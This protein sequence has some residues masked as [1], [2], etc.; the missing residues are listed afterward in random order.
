MFRA[1]YSSVDRMAV[2]QALGECASQ[3]GDLDRKIIPAL[4]KALGDRESWGVREAAAKALG[5]SVEQWGGLAGEII[6][7]L[8]NALDDQRLAVSTAAGKALGKGAAQ[9]RELAKEIISELFKILRDEKLLKM[10]RDGA[11]PGILIEARHALKECMSQMEGWKSV[12]RDELYYDREAEGQASENTAEKVKL[13]TLSI[14]KIFNYYSLLQK[15]RKNQRV[16][17]EDDIN[18]KR[19]WILKLHSILE[20]KVDPDDVKYVGQIADITED[21]DS[22]RNILNVIRGWAVDGSSDAQNFLEA[23]VGQIVSRD[24]KAGKKYV[25]ITQKDKLFIE[26]MAKSSSLDSLI[27]IFGSNRF[28]FD[29][30]IKVG[31]AL[32]GKEYIDEEYLQLMADNNVEQYLDMIGRFY[33]KFEEVPSF[34]FINK[35]VIEKVGFEYEKFNGLVQNVIESGQRRYVNSLEG[36]F[37]IENI[38]SEKFREFRN[39]LTNAE[40]GLRERMSIFDDYI[41]IIMF[42]QM[43]EGIDNEDFFMRTLEEK[44]ETLDEKFNEISVSGISSSKARRIQANISKDVQG[45]RREYLKHLLQR[46]LNENEDKLLA[47]QKI[48]KQVL[49]LSG[50]LSTLELSADCNDEDDVSDLKTIAIL[51]LNN[52]FINFD[53]GSEDALENAKRKLREFLTGFSKEDMAKAIA[54]KEGISEESAAEQLGEFKSNKEV[55]EELVEAGYDKRL[56]AEGVDISTDLLEG[57]TQEMKDKWMK[58]SSYEMVEIALLAGVEEID[59]QTVSLENSGELDNYEKVKIFHEKVIKVGKKIPE[60]LS[61]RL[62]DIEDYIK[63]VDLMRIAVVEKNAFRATIKKDFLNE[64]TAGV[65]VPGCFSPTGIHREMPIIH[66]LEANVMFMQVYSEKGKQ[67]GN[68]VIV[69]GKEGAYVYTGYNASKYNLDSVFGKALEKLAEYVPSIFLTTTSAG[70]TYM[71]AFTKKKDGAVSI[72]KPSTV[73][74]TQYFDSGR[75]DEDGVLTVSLNDPMH[76]TKDML[77]E[78]VFFNE[79]VVKN[80]VGG[81]IQVDVNWIELVNKLKEKQLMPY[82]FLISSL[83]KKIMQEGEVVANDEFY[84]WVEEEVK[85]KFRGKINSEVVDDISDILLDFLKEQDWPIDIQTPIQSASLDNDAMLGKDIDVGSPGPGGIDFNLD[86]LELEIQ[87]QGRDFNL[88]NMDRSFEH[89]CIDDGLFPVIINITPVTNLPVILGVAESNGEQSSNPYLVI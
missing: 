38:S 8:M 15:E 57:I 69:F 44:M 21:R 58:Q 16:V 12:H 28:P 22:L 84:E 33:G 55:V 18:S 45:V 32:A 40:I 35:V 31:E 74:K 60:E 3:W 36:L 59:G 87:G 41:G 76:I 85:V 42:D 50:I 4:V 1:E 83:K 14:E 43:S 49:T 19:A 34:E 56:W 11:I 9:G 29:V 52:L 13:Q 65:G 46:D 30:R 63:R 10:R 86:L 80:L 7:A 73:I 81:Q 54:R 89:I 68:A 26:S 71:S 66:A 2:V 53:P 82:Q 62:R 23:K 37:E 72:E 77:P 61:E 64:V 51:F 20:G 5:K 17:S 78:E 70:Y 6:S 24:V 88:P 79:K 67:V 48:L 47:D 27:T 39:V 25:D 75:V